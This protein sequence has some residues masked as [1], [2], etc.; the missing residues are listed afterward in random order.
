[1]GS[2]FEVAR[3][4]SN[5][6]GK[7]QAN[8]SDRQAIDE[9]LSKSRTGGSPDDLQRDITDIISRVSPE[10]QQAVIGAVKTRYEESKKQ[11]SLQKKKKFL[12]EYDLPEDM[13]YMSDTVINKA[14]E[15]KLS[16]ET[17]GD[18]SKDIKD[19][20]INAGYPEETANEYANLYKS[21]TVGGKT[22]V[23]KSVD[24]LIRRK[25]VGKGRISEPKKVALNPGEMSEFSD[26]DE[27]IFPDIEPPEGLTGKEEAKYKSDLRK[28]NSP[29]FSA[30][31]KIVA[32]LRKELSDLKLLDNINERENLPEGTT[33]W[34]NV[35]VEPK[36][37]GLRPIGQI[38]KLATPDMEQ[39][40]KILMG[41]TRRAKDS[42]G[43]KVTNFDLE[44]LLKT[45]PNL[46]NSKEGRRR[47]NKQMQIV[48]Q[49]DALHSDALKKVYAHYRL[50]NIPQEKADEIAESN[51][52]EQ[53]KVLEDEY[54]KIGSELEQIAG[55]SANDQPAQKQGKLTPLEEEMKRRGLL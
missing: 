12:K 8:I 22:A 27:M 45:F 1:M 26:K 55:E 25:P 10:K 21:S 51:I 44:T 9:I 23:I 33:D 53:L 32:N 16:K 3:A 4:I 52:E 34:K 37:G 2:P 14:I 17:T 30:L 11:E 19:S 38:L 24:E 29:I 50:E 41:F 20:L 18:Q 47:I 31:P 54:Q 13:A 49:I 46:L 40:I 5:N 7:L 39:Y 35:L 42:F 48:N 15:A 28:E 36:T 43:A 6:L